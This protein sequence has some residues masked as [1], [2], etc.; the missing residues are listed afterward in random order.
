MQK[1]LTHFYTEVH[2]HRP[3]LIVKQT[4]N[5]LFIILAGPKS[6]S[7]IP[8]NYSGVKPYMQDMNR[9]EEKIGNSLL[10]LMSK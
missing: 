8:N 5:G 6:G 10:N 7:S 9:D 3:I 2:K 1:M 4:N